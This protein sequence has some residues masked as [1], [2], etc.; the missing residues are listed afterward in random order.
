MSGSGAPA[1][2]AAAS[3]NGSDYELRWPPRLIA[4][5]L[6]ALRVG[7]NVRERRKQIESL[8][9]EVFLGET[10]ALGFAAGLPWTHVVDDPWGDAT[11]AAAVGL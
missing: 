5:E 3:L 7:G 8:L 1:P 9:E 2:A 4:R 11:P 10:P 6:A